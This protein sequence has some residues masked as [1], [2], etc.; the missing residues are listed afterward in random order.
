LEVTVATNLGRQRRAAWARRIAAD[1][2]AEAARAAT[3]LKDITRQIR[4]IQ[5]AGRTT[6]SSVAALQGAGV[7]TAVLPNG[8]RTRMRIL[9]TVAPIGELNRLRSVLIVNDRRQAIAIEKN[10]RAIASLAAA[11]ADAVR[12]LTAQQV[13][14]D[15]ELRKRLVEAD[16][17]LDRRM[18]RQITR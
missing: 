16:D 5:T 10:S 12:R 18:T 4:S 9:P 7:V 11:Q 13:K 1:Q 17:R 6:L 2:R 14:S 15:K 8:R 3:L